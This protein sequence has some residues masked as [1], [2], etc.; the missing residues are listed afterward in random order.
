MSSSCQKLW[1]GV[2]D[3]KIENKANINKLLFIPEETKLLRREI[4]SWFTIDSAV[5][6]M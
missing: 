6:L 2:S 4:Y 1:G 5:S 3:E